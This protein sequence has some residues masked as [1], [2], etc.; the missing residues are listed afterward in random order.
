MRLYLLDVSG[1]G[2]P[3]AMLSVT[4][5]MVLSPESAQGSPLKRYNATT[6][7]HEVVSPSEVI[8]DLN[9]RF[10]SKDDRYFTMIYGLVDT[11]TGKLTLTQAGH[12]SP[13]LIHQGQPLQLLG[14]GGVPVGL[15]PDMEYETIHATL[16]PGDKLVLYSDAVTECANPVGAL[17]G[18]ERLINYLSAARAKCL[19]KMLEGLEFEMEQ[20]RGRGEFDDDV[21]LFALEFTGDL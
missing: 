3:A 4:L 19:P 18:E 20:W 14:E 8:A 9:R 5:S 15:C 16:S 7:S 11:H 1:H 6:K 21:S 2:V 10:Q 13:V 12:P 17:F